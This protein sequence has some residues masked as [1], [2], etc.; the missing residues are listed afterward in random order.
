MDQGT[1]VFLLIIAAILLL[2]FLSGKNQEKK[3]AADYRRK[4]KEQF[5]KAPLSKCPEEQR[6]HLSGYFRKHP[7]E[8]QIDGITW[9]DLEL[10][11]IYDRINYTQSAEG[12]E[13]L[14]W[15]LRTPAEGEDSLSLTEPQ[16]SAMQENEEYR[17]RL[18]TELHRSAQR[19]KY[20]LYDY[21]DAID[22]V[23]RRSVFSNL[24]AI[25]LLALSVLLFFVSVPG[26]VV[27]LFAVLSFNILTYYRERAGIDPYFESMKMIVR[28]SNSAG[29]V[30]SLKASGEDVFAE[31]KKE[32]LGITHELS[33]LN[34]TSFLLSSGS[35]GNPAD[36][37]L[38]YLRIL[39]HLDLIGF[40]SMLASISERKAEIDRLITL[41]GKIDATISV[42]LFRASLPWWTAP[43]FLHPSR[44]DG[45][46]GEKDAVL[47]EAADLYHPLLMNPV[48]N[49]IATDGYVLVTGSNASGKSTFLKASALCSLLS[50][51][52]RTAPAREYRGCFFRIYT[53]M[54]LRDD[55]SE[56]ESYF[57]VEIRSLKRI[58]DAAARTRDP[59]RPVLCFIDEVLRGTNT[60]ERIA[61][62][63]EIL[64][65]FRLRG[66]LAFA[67][68]H[69]IELTS[70]LEKSYANYHFD[71][72]I[73]NGDIRFNYR[74]QKGKASS[75]NAIRLLSMIG[76]D[77]DITKKAE[78]RAT[79]FAKTGEW[80]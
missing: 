64:D 76:Y 23:K 34:R 36:I 52:I 37:F 61:A 63:S 67:A 45:T 26:A 1:I 53:S 41:M 12:E 78:E 50:Q 48:P 27:A 24:Y 4:L 72:T 57:I 7:A 54:A 62:S 60:V 46:S 5:G 66:I 9:S 74:L 28:L 30:G 20:S 58:L 47:F 3:A 49:S 31:E 59:D 14:Y 70:L 15:L 40:Y 32:I 11:R 19:G 35:S 33:G 25:L 42:S 43:V 6:A 2:F 8:N 71:E 75:R 22:E 17:I 10:D 16:I 18:E 13:Y 39:L 68:T 65:S 77:E 21:I 51:T 80:T 44:M 73:E 55:L 69:D 56:G 38:D 29:R 79:R